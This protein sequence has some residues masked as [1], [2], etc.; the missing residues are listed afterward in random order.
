VYINQ[1]PCVLSELM[2]PLVFHILLRLIQV[3]IEKGMLGGHRLTFHGMADEAV[4]KVTGD[5]VIVLDERPAPAFKFK[6]QG[7]CGGTP[8]RTPACRT[9]RGIIFGGM[10]WH[11]RAQRQLLHV[12]CRQYR[13]RCWCGDFCVIFSK[14]QG[15][16]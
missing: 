13:L 4:G 11:E 3:V 5:V 12:R 14:L 15:W 16:T 1:S 6:R 7:M 8:A 2:L 10:K 9:A